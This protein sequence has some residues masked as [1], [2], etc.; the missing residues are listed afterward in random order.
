MPNDW[1]RSTTF[2]LFWSS[3]GAVRLDREVVDLVERQSP[4][5]VEWVQEHV[6]RLA[7]R[8]LELTASWWI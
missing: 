1:G 2:G 7:H 5:L 8:S 6:A 3:R 4:G